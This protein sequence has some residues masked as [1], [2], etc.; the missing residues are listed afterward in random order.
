MHEPRLEPCQTMLVI[1]SL[2]AIW[3]RWTCIWTWTHLIYFVSPSRTPDYSFNWT[4]ESTIIHRNGMYFCRQVVDYIEI[5]SLRWKNG[6]FPSCGSVSTTKWMH[7]IDFNATNREKASWELNKYAT[8]CF[9]Q[10]L[11]AEPHET[12]TVRPLTSH[13]P[14]CPRKTNETCWGLMV[15]KVRTKTWT[16]FSHG[17]LR[18]EAPGLVD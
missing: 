18:M 5:Q 8:S 1:G 2:S 10:I 13:L 3:A 12:V 4:K 11:V 7:H 15:E 6:I 17:F 16:S 14:N 9:Q